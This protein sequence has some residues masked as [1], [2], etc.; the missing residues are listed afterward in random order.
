MEFIEKKAFTIVG[1]GID[2]TVQECP[3]VLP[4]LWAEFMKRCSEIKNQENEMTQYGLCITKDEKEC[5]FRYI[6]GVEINSSNFSDDQI[7]KGMEKATVPE[8]RY[9]LWMHTGD[10]ME[11]GQSYCKIMEELKQKGIKETG[12]WFELYDERYKPENPDSE[13][14]IYCGVAKD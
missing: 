4:E 14:D 5:S 6:A 8:G 13:M 2:S 10:V 11:I 7:P 1:M 3:K 12:T 9:A